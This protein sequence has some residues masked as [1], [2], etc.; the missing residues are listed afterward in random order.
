[1][2]T[3]PLFL[4]P[5]LPADEPPFEVVLDG[6]EGHHAAR[7]R[8]LHAGEAIWLGD[9]F[10]GVLRGSVAAVERDRVRVAVASRSQQPQPSPRLVVVQA[11]PKSDRVEIT[12]ELLTE[13]GVAE[14]VPWRAARCVGQWKDDRSPGKWRRTVAEAAKQSRR[15]WVPVVAEP[16]STAA[17]ARRIADA[18]S[19]VVL[20]ESASTDLPALSAPD[21]DVLVVVGPEG[22]IAD[23]ELDAFELAGAH[24]V[25]LGGPVLRTS[26]AGAAALA[27]LSVRLGRW[28]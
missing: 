24:L 23:E 16:A 2:S 19:T 9:G 3:P 15:P 28:G 14:I 4:L 26:S 10:G 17:V 20:H 1:M 11:V 12:L 7:V 25:R 18:A 13:L 27:A 22:G 5:S 6:A 21:G 8:R